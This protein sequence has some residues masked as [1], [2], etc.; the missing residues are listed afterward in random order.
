MA[1]PRFTYSPRGLCHLRIFRFTK[2]ARGA[3]DTA[4]H[5]R[6]SRLVR[7]R[8]AERGDRSETLL[9]PLMPKL[10]RFAMGVRGAKSR[11]SFAV[12]HV[13][14]LQVHHGCR[15]ARAAKWLRR[16]NQP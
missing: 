9:Q 10:C 12:T 15:S 16:K 13:E 4:L 8:L 1:R 5:P 2:D 7:F 3:T 14:A 6:M 11:H